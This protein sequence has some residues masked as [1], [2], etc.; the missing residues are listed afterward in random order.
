MGW[1]VRPSLSQALDRDAVAV[2]QRGG[3]LKEQAAQQQQVRGRRGVGGQ[4]RSA[5]VG[6]R[7]VL[8]VGHLARQQ[9]VAGS[10]TKKVR[11]KN[12]RGNNVRGKTLGVLLVPLGLLFE[13]PGQ[14]V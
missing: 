2:S 1:R 14:Q 11:G 3:E 5:A 7:H 12:V 4:S 9:R 8:Q 6:R 13:L 10:R